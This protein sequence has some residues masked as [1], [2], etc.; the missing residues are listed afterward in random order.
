MG[1]HADEDYRAYWDLVITVS[2]VIDGVESGDINFEEAIEKLKEA[3]PI[4]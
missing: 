4:Q 2:D 3:I 1:Y